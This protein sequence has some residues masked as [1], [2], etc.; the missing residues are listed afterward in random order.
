MLTNAIRD[1]STRRGSLPTSLVL[2]LAVLVFFKEY[3]LFVS[4][5]VLLF[6]FVWI[7][8]KKKQPK[9]LYPRRWS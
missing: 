4:V 9:P 8:R 3:E 5:I 6:C 1:A 2:L 7:R